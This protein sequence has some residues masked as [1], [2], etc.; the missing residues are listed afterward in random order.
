V[1]EL[2]LDCIAV[3]IIPL[4]TFQLSVMAAPMETEL[5]ETSSGT[6]QAEVTDYSCAL[7][8]ELGSNKGHNCLSD[9]AW[10]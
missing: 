1:F 4:P 3:L 10:P 7:D 6:P 5:V 9:L 8:S 2:S